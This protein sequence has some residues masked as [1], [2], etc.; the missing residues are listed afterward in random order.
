MEQKI[1]TLRKSSIMKRKEIEMYYRSKYF[2]LFMNGYEFDG[3]DYQQQRFLL[4][5]LWEKG[6]IACFILEGSKPISLLID[7]NKQDE[8]QGELILTP[9]STSKFNIYNFP[10]MVQLIKLRGVN[11]IPTTPQRV[12]QDVV[13][14]WGHSSHMPIR[15]IVDFYVDKITEVEIT[16][17]M[18]LETHKLPRLVVCGPED[19]KRVE[20]L[21]NKIQ[22]GVPQL[23][24]DVDDIK[25]IQ[26]VLQSGGE[27]I[28]DK[29]FTYKQNLERELMTILG[30]DN[31][32]TLKRER[33][34]NDEVNANNEEIDNG[35]DCFV[36][37]MN[38][39]C[40]QVSD[41]LGYKISVREKKP[42]V[43][44]MDTTEEDTSVND[45]EEGEEQ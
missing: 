34:N 41:V 43:E 28:V 37:E 15:S 30:I 4:S 32:G 11:F 36:D 22:D 39:F 29:V 45:T 21:M 31:I 3:L 40:K 38:I 26:N 42:G 44:M 10:E 7:E 24:L 19:K 5:Q 18:N 1:K 8:N 12:N 13:I 23:F 9:Y 14:G 33:Q 35:G 20:E 17:R 2:S 25:A 27:F 16:A 6:T